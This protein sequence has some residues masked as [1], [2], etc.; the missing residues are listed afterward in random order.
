ML[1]A[2][3]CSEDLNVEHMRKPRQRMPIAHV[4]GGKRPG[5]S[6]ARQPLLNM[7]IVADVAGIVVIDEI[8]MNRRCE[9]QE[10]RRKQKKANDDFARKLFEVVADDHFFTDFSLNNYPH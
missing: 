2:G 8:K 7:K 9:N 4:P 10:N 3:F 6:V 1:P 5:N